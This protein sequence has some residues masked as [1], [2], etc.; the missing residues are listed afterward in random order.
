MKLASF[1]IISI[2]F[3]AAILAYPVSFSKTGGE[4]AIFVTLL[5]GG[6]KGGQGAAGE[7]GA[8][9]K[10]MRRADA[11]PQSRAGMTKSVRQIVSRSVDPG[12]KTKAGDPVP[13]IVQEFFDEGITFTGLEGKGEVGGVFLGGMVGGNGEGKSG[14]EG[15]FTGGLGAGGLGMGDGPQG[16]GF[17]RAG[18]AYNPKPKYPETARQEGWEGTVLLRVLVDREGMSKSIEVSRSS[19][20]ETLDRAAMETVQ[21]WRFRPAHYGERRVESWVRIPIVFSLA[22]LKN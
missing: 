9:R 10:G 14:G 1:F 16:F 18:Y 21:S 7:G 3:H 12:D 8:E 5:G 17:G 13:L 22:D 2:A 15:N 6:G 20:F 11:A 19:G 4:E